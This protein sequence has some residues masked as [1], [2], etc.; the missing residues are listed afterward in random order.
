MVAVILAGSTYG[1]LIVNPYGFLQQYNKSKPVDYN[2]DTTTVTQKQQQPRIHDR[3]KLIYVDD[4]YSGLSQ[5][6]YG[7]VTGI[8][9]IK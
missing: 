6:M 3:V 4:E 2:S 1:H 9:V 7:A 8:S 5:G